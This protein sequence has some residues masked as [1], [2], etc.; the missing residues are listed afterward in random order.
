V[1]FSEASTKL[2]L[3]DALMSFNGI[4]IEVLSVVATQVKTIQERRHR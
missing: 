2:E 4:P 1:T 3:G